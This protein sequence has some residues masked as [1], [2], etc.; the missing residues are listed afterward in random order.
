MAGPMGAIEHSTDGMRAVLRAGKAMLFDVIY[1]ALGCGVRS[2]LAS[3]LG[4]KTNRVGCLEVDSH[5]DGGWDLCC[6]R[7][8]AGSLICV[9]IPICIS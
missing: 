8:R 3:A 2:E 4:A 5:H 1:P 6:R 7:R 9:R